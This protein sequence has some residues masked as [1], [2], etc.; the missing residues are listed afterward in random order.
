M[1]KGASPEES[2]SSSRSGGSLRVVLLLGFASAA[3]FCLG[4]VATGWQ[5]RGEWEAVAA[6]A[7]VASLQ[8]ERVRQR[9]FIQWH[10]LAIGRHVTAE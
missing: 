5:L 4:Q 8:I 3:S 6:E 1:D 9:C 10:N 2:G 7:R